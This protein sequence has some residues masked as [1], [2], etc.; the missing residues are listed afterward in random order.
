MHVGRRP[1]W[2]I[3]V[4]V[5]LAACQGAPAPRP[6]EKSAGTL[7][8]EALERG[9]YAGAAELY[10]TAVGNEP[11]SLPWHYGLGVA[12][13]YLDRRPETVEQFRWVLEHGEA[14]SLEV[15]TAR[16]WLL[17]AGALP[18]AASS[19]ASD[20]EAKA[21]E[22]REEATPAEQKPRRASV[23]GRVLYGEGGA[24]PVPVKMMGLY[25]S[26]YPNR[27]K[28]FRALTDEEGRFRFADVPPGTYKLSDRV[29]GPPR[30]RL[31]AE[32]KP[33]QQLILDLD[34]GNSTEVRDD[35]PD[36]SSPRSRRPSS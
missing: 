21:E 3:A 14:D 6:A 29:A 5:G 1:W 16:S 31:R 30:W 19:A 12:S 27:V 18:R 22:P 24:A 32:L 2:L 26:D 13:S 8:A 15:K 23:Q 7:A 10:R 20:E 34:P 4:A 33:G 35:F 28:R 17:S 9:D 25:L 36:A 11:Q